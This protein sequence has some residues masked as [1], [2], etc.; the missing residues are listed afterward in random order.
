MKRWL[1]GANNPT[2][3][4]DFTGLNPNFVPTVKINVDVQPS[5]QIR[6]LEV[7]VTLSSLNQSV[8]EGVLTTQIIGGHIPLRRTRGGNMVPNFDK[9]IANELLNFQPQRDSSSKFS[10]KSVIQSQQHCDLNISENQVFRF[11]VPQN[12]ILNS[13]GSLKHDHINIFL[14]VSG[15]SATP[16]QGAGPVVPSTNSLV[17]GGFNWVVELDSGGATNFQRSGEI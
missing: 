15:A 9:A 3:F 13:D 2:T 12:Q 5:R 4:V 14:N 16:H 8:T 7:K 10:T 11:I 1:Y 17:S 6:G